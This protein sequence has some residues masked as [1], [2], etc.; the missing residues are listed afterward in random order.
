MP[1]KLLNGSLS[2]DFLSCKVSAGQFSDVWLSNPPFTV[3]I[4]DRIIVPIW[5]DSSIQ[6]VIIDPTLWRCKRKLYSILF[7]TVR[8]HKAATVCK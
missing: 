4:H 3:F 7:K 5:Y 8:F 2:V 1:L 6:G